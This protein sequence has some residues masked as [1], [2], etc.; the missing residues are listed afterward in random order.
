QIAYPVQPSLTLCSTNQ[1]ANCITTRGKPERGQGSLSTGIRVV[2][3][4]IRANSG[5]APSHVPPDGIDLGEV[6]VGREASGKG[7]P[8]KGTPRLLAALSRRE[9][10][11]SGSP[12]SA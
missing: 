12:G 7:V 8:E 1:P 5:L 4:A 9:A 2:N 11:S 6:A 3:H 10:R